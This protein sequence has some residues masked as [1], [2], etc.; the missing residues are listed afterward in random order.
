MVTANY[1]LMLG[2][3]SALAAVLGF[4]TH[5]GHSYLAIWPDL[6]W[7]WQLRAR[8]PEGRYAWADYDEEGFWEFA[9]MRNVLL[10][11][12]TNLAMVWGFGFWFWDRQEQ[13]LAAVCSGFRYI[14]TTP[15]FCS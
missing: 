11:V 3:F 9:S 14:G 15:L 5:T 12:G 7:K 10:Y 4:A 8:S 1:L 6:Y 2:V 13:A